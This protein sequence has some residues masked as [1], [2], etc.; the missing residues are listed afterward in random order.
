LFFRFLHERQGQVFITCTE[1]SPL[2][3]AG[4]NRIR[5]FRVKEGKLCDY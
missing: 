3:E 2:R 5:T 1:I 4:F